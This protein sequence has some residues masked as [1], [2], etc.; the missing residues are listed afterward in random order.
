MS[1]VVDMQAYRE[2]RSAN[3]VADFSTHPS[4]K[5]VD[6]MAEIVKQNLANNLQRISTLLGG[7]A[8]E[9]IASGAIKVEIY[10]FGEDVLPHGMIT[11]I[12]ERNK[13]V[14][15]CLTN[16]T[17]L[18]FEDKVTNDVDGENPAKVTALFATG[19]LVAASVI[20]TRTVIN[21]G[22]L[23]RSVWG[24]TNLEDH[25]LAREYF[26]FAGGVVTQIFGDM[27]FDAPSAA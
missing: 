23:D 17:A 14:N 19:A 15:L 7:K 6:W 5:Q 22:S 3:T 24:R 20:Q 25:A 4:A 27:G 13:T 1:K 11:V 21:R 16:N 2:R 18:L 12:K 8:I 26:R 9:P 10:S